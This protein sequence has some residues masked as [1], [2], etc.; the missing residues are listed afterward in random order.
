M[1]KYRIKIVRDEFAENPFEAW[2]CEPEL[3]YDSSG[4]YDHIVT[5]VSEGRILEAIKDK[6][7]AEIVLSNKEEI[8]DILEISSEFDKDYTKEEIADEILYEID[9]RLSV[10]QYA[11]LCELLKIPHLRYDS[12][13]YSQGDYAD[14]LLVAT[15]KFFEDT[16]CDR[17]KVDDILEGSR[18]L[19]DA[20][21][22]GDVY[23]FEVEKATE[24]VRLTREDFDTGK[25]E[26]VEDDIEW[27]YHDSCFGFYGEDIEGIVEN[28]GV[29]KEVVEDAF[30]LVGEWVEFEM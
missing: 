6:A 19:F 11:A 20:W 18:K 29:P 5:D 12:R 14:V 7:T 21:A 26:N 23:G 22:W 30:N 15:D 2:D 16:G 4:R 27:D 17:D 13:G 3:M 24:M 1:K 8:C 9:S 25:F 28:S 10:K